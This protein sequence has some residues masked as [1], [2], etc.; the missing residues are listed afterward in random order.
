MLSNMKKL[1]Y[2]LPLLAAGLYINAQQSM[3]NF[4]KLQVHGGVLAIDGNLLNNGGGDFRS[5]GQLI[6]KGNITNHQPAMAYGSG[7]LILNGASTQQI[8]GTQPWRTQHLITRNN[9]GI[10]L[11]ANLE[12]G[13]QHQFMAGIIQTGTNTYMV[14]ADGATYSGSADNRHVAGWVRRSGT[15]DFTFP[16]GNGS[17]LRPMQVSSV[18]EASTYEVRYQQATPYTNDIHNGLVAVASSEYWEVQTVTGGAAIIDLAWDHAKVAMP[19]WSLSEIRVARLG[20]GTWSDAGGT[21]TGNP[22]A[23]GSIAAPSMPLSGLYTF[24][25][26]SVP[27]PL[28]LVS[29]SAKRS[30]SITHLDWQT[31]AEQGVERFAVERSADGLHFTSIGSLPARNRGGEER[32]QWQDAGAIGPVAYYRLRCIDKDG[33]VKMSQV[34]AVA[35]AVTNNLA[36]VTNPVLHTAQIRVPQRLGGPCQ[37]T[38]IGLGGQVVQQGKIALPGGGIAALAL[39]Q[40]LVPGVYFLKLQSASQQHVLRFVRE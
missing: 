18:Q 32:Y 19:A 14:Y 37:Y 2:L 16:V 30:S 36:L 11:V 17:L 22:A 4:G 34:V 25:Q 38:I 33:K 26:K 40:Q 20:G 3:A 29:F 39:G 23:E 9:A 24:G 31:V 1:I 27:L 13:G 28:T 21:A 15:A 6:V 12:V 8:G 10:S 7:T 5:N 35:N